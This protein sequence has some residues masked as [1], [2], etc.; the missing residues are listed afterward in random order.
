MANSLEGVTKCRVAA[1][2]AARGFTADPDILGKTMLLSGTA[3]TIVGVVSPEYDGNFL[4]FGPA[5]YVPMMMKARMTPT[6]DALDDRRTRFVNAFGR[7]KPGVS[8]AQAEGFYEVHKDRPFFGELVEFM[9]SGPVVVSA[10]EGP[11]AIALNRELMGATFYPLIVASLVVASTIDGAAQPCY[12]ILPK[13]YD[14]KGDPA[15]LFKVRAMT[16][17]SHSGSMRPKDG[18]PK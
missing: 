16:P 10:L 14:P 13:G 18:R 3:Y 6:W 8:R 12:V 5:V 17:V 9:T 11:G 2:L 7:L 1:E 15:P 4:G